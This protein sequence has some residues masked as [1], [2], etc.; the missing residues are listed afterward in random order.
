MPVTFVTAFLDLNKVEKR[1]NHK[2]TLFYIEKG[3]EL[4]S[5]PYSFAVFIDKDSYQL[6][7][8]KFKSMT[9][10]TFHIIDFET[11]PVY[12]LQ[13]TSQ[14]L[15]LPLG[16]NKEKDTYHYLCVNISKTYLVEKAIEIDPYQSTHF[17]WIDF[18]ILHIINNNSPEKECFANSLRTISNYNK[19]R[20]R[21]PGCF[22]PARLRELSL[23]SFKDYPCWAFCGGFFCGEKNLLCSFSKDV[24][25]VLKNLDFMTWELN[26]WAHI[27]N[28]NKKSESFDWYKADHNISILSNF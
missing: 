11:L 22:D 25:D 2:N 6:I 21:I 4:I 20:I 17:A 9:N 16:R 5:H 10:I 23:L 1:P 3:I 15:N 14:N 13:L 18:G 7:P 27:Y 28:D 24:L 8:E 26:I 12:Q 19:N